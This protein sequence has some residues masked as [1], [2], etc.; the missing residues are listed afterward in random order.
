MNALNPDVQQFMIDLV[1]ALLVSYPSID[2][3]QG[4]DRMP[5]LPSI[6]GY[7]LYTVKQYQ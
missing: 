4:D 5:A 1:D 3:I 7:D 6:A 2:G